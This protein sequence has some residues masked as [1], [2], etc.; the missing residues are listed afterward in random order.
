V[1]TLLEPH[2][3]LPLGDRDLG[4]GVDEVAEEMAGLGNLVTIPD[5]NAQ[6][7]IEAARQGQRISNT[8]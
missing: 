3:D 5:A 1:G 6:Q 8:L 4:R 7:S 2:D